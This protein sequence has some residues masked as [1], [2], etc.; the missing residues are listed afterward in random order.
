MVNNSHPTRR[1]FTLVELSFVILFLSVLLMAVLFVS[2][3][4]GKIYAKGI[5]FKSVNQVNR[6][7]VDSMRRDF[8]GANASNIQVV[9]K[10]NGAA[11]NE[12]AGRICTG[13]V[14]YVW[15]T[16]ALLNDTGLGANALKLTAKGNA[17][18]FMRVP[19]TGGTL[20]QSGPT[21]PV[22]RDISSYTG[23]TEL[24]SANG[25]DLAVYTM[26]L[27]PVVT[28]VAAGRGVYQLSMQIGTNDQGATMLDVNGNYVCRPPSDQAANFDYCTVIDA[29][30]MLR[31]SGEIR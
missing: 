26:Q 15:N 3:Q 16:A 11:L 31:A 14:S 24:L 25:R 30:T 13:T 18:N 6:E 12:R 9:I 7:L 2:V 20:C 19:D 1:G 23:V 28:D 8:A 22:V 17:I 10:T 29:D 21:S 4:I 5:T 27:S